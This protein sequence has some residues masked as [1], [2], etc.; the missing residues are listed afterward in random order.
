MKGVVL[1]DTLGRSI[2]DGNQFC[3]KYGIGEIIKSFSR[4]EKDEF[5]NSKVTDTTG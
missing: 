1:T 5:T 3:L 4:L 2:N